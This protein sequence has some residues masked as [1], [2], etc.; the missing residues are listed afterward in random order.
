MSKTG[1]FN[2]KTFISFVDVIFNIIFGNAWE[3][4]DKS[5]FFLNG[6]IQ[7]KFIC[8]TFCVAVIRIDFDFFILDFSYRLSIYASE[9]ISSWCVHFSNLCSFVQV[10]V[11]VIQASM[12]T[13]TN[14]GYIRFCA[15]HWINQVD[16]GI[17]WR[18]VWTS[19]SACENNWNWC[20]EHKT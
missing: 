19:L 7:F 11:V 2:H 13:H 5:N 16:V 8:S 20:F 3:T 12:H 1:S 17:T 18:S 15:N 6:C 4:F 14:F 9:S 10:S